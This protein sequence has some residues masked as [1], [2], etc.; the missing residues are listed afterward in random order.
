MA[1]AVDVLKDE[2]ATFA[3][4]HGS[5]AAGNAFQS[6]ILMS[7]RKT[8]RRALTFCCRLV[9][10]CC[11]RHRP[12]R[13]CGD[14]RVRQA[15]LRSGSDG[16]SRIEIKT[17]KIYFD[18]LARSRVRIRSLRKACVVPPS[19]TAATNHPTHQASVKTTKAYLSFS[20]LASAA[21]Q[22]ISSSMTWVGICSLR[23]GTSERRLGSRATCILR[24]GPKRVDN[25]PTCSASR[26]C[27]RGVRSAQRCS[28]HG[29]AKR[30]LAPIGA[31]LMFTGSPA[32]HRRAN[33]AESSR[34]LP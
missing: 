2:A 25:G 21:D 19:P 23:A 11:P 29:G 1:Q 8:R 30:A 3:Y 20:A 4:L 22:N 12:V 27:Q 33:T 9:S 14:C 6:P 13:T 18:D 7:P 17:R 15:A 5:R 28:R 26:G 34:C 10:I 24:R 32:L 16:E 31:G